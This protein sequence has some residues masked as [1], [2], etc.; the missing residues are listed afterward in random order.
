MGFQE[1]NPSIHVLWFAIMEIDDKVDLVRKEYLW[2][3]KFLMC[4]KDPE[5]ELHIFRD[6]NRA[7]E[8]WKLLINL[9]FS[10][11]F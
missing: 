1:P 6:Y 5:Q 11:E 4:E 9:T 8:V 10:R 2:L 3:T 7:N